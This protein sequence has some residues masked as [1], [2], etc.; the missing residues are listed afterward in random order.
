VTA[1]VAAALWLVWLP[2]AAHAQSAI[3][4]TVRDETGAVVPGATIEASSPALIEKVRAAVTD[5]NGQYKI[6]DLRPGLYSVTITLTGFNAVKRDGIDLPAN[7]TAQVNAVLMAGAIAETLV[8]TSDSPVVDVQNAVVQNV[9]SRQVLDSIPTGR[10]YQSVGQ[11]APGITVDRPD[12]GGSEAFFATNL[13]VH[14]SGISDQSFQLD[15]IDLSDGEADGRYTGM[16]RDDGDNEEIVYQTS[17]ITAE[18]SRGGVRVNMIGRTGSNQFRSAAFLGYTPGTLQS[19]NLS[20]AIIAAGLPTPESMRHAGDFNFTLGG[21]VA[22]DKIWFFSSTREW[23]IYKYAAGAFYSDGSR[24]TDDMVHLAS[25][26]RLTMQPS[27]KDKV[28][29]Y[30]ARMLKRTLY[31]RYVGPTTTPEASALQTTPIAHNILAKWT[32]TQSNRLL[33]D[34]GWIL[35]MVHPKIWP[36]PAVVADPT[37]ISKRDLGTGITYDAN[38]TYLDLYD[39]K[40]SAQGSASYVTGSHSFKTGVQYGRPIYRTS[41]KVNGDLVQNYLF[42][43]PTSV[44]VYNTPLDHTD[45]ITDLGAYAQDAWTIGHMTVNYGLRFEHFNGMMKAQDLGAGQFVPPRHFAALENVPNWNNWTPR[46][47]LVYDVSGNGKTAVKVSANKYMVG[48]SVSFTEN[49]LPISTL[50]DTRTWRDLNGD[51][52][53]QA[54]EIGPSN[55]SNFGTRTVNTIDPGLK[56]PY[57]V[58][59][60]AGIQ[61]ELRTGMALT[62]GYF[63][64]QYYNLTYTN[65]T[66]LTASDYIPV[67]IVTPIDGPVLTI[68]NLDPAKRG[69]V[70]LVDLTSPN[71]KNIYNGVELSLT[72]RLN[73][74][75]LFGGI[76]SGKRTVNNCDGP[77][78]VGSVTYYYPDPNLLRFC[79]ST[80]YVSWQTQVKLTGT[81]TLPL[82]FQVSGTF[83]SNPGNPVGAAS[84][85]VR[86]NPEMG[87]QDI[88]NVTRAVVPNLTQATVTVNLIAPGSRYL[89]RVNQ[90]DMRFGRRFTVR[91]AKLELS[92][93][94]FNILNS[95]PLMRVN[96][97]YG[98]AFLRP[99]EVLQ[100]RTLRLTANIQL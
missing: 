40:W 45:L 49:Y 74:A 44:T 6:I 93:D 75:M 31:N 4:G 80:S 55:I 11:T 13:F 17:A 87:L 65:N 85:T 61:R 28:Q 100:A 23:G 69:L 60:N 59:Y 50:T 30:Y 53:A 96:E 98:P 83:Q 48:Q 95:A 58:E 68:Y 97:A 94:L 29:V 90:L 39:E 46:F 42:G 92:A 24:A 35:T 1:V 36:Q 26:L 67:N 82:N 63:R 43:V 21:P 70:Q 7:F 41:L 47:G 9:V 3:A 2:G 71:N 34:A 72:G 33:L 8:V 38:P 77:A 52:I 73:K 54:N 78:T 86:A 66:A 22:R 62:A 88:Y 37:I 19:N 51:N 81:Y 99:N 15:G 14:G 84:A 16:Y 18:T 91:R 27:W 20:P 79:D 32:S 12:V 89:D 57:Q 25:S 76:T 5:G 10:S 56:R 64:R